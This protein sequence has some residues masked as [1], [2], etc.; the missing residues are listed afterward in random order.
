MCFCATTFP[1]KVNS[2]K[3]TQFSPVSQTR[4]LRKPCPAVHAQGMERA[5]SKQQEL[6]AA[7]V[8]GNITATTLNPANLLLNLPSITTEPHHD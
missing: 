5:L 3:A 8:R 2:V 1:T 6:L 7:G 4:R